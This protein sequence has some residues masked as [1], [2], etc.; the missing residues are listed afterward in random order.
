MGD[1][2]KIG[3]ENPACFNE[4]TYVQG[5]CACQGKVVCEWPI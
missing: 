3:W 5:H 4:N 1:G 2:L